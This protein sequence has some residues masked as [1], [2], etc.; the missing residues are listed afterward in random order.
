[1]NGGGIYLKWRIY[2]AQFCLG[3]GA[4]G[5]ENEFISFWLPSSNTSLWPWALE[6]REWIP[7]VY[8]E[9][10][11]INWSSLRNS[12]ALLL[13]SSLGKSTKAQTPRRSKS[14]IPSHKPLRTFWTPGI[15]FS[16]KGLSVEAWRCMCSEG[17]FYLLSSP[18]PN[19]SLTPSSK[20]FFYKVRIVWGLSS[21]VHFVWPNISLSI[22]LF[23]FSF[24]WMRLSVLA[25]KS[26]L[27][28]KA[29]PITC[30]IPPLYSKAQQSNKGLFLSVPSFSFPTQHTQPW[31]SVK[32]CLLSKSQFLTNNFTSTWKQPR[33]WLLPT[34]FFSCFLLRDLG[35]SRRE[36]VHQS[37]GE[38]Q[39][40]DLP[41]PW[42]GGP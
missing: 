22:S 9:R 23:L 32:S 18:L 12:G 16:S 27:L 21:F 39:G 6:R 11:W 41:R 38:P 35:N 28:S 33:L 37:G 2:S 31:P 19:N 4:F 34:F 25:F 17:Q 7:N 1:M 14:V 3:Y 10:K 42:A 5:K 13:T 15:Q 20:Y 40:Q 36:H 8:L 29:S 24:T 30:W 26:C